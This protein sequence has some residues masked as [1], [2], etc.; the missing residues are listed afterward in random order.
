MITDPLAS[1]FED[2][3]RQHILREEVALAIHRVTHPHCHDPQHL[4]ELDRAR[5][6][7]AIAA[8]KDHDA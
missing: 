8:V 3:L 4:T 5:A 2:Y 1:D 6:D 7:A